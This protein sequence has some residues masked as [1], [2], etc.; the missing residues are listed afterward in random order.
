MVPNGAQWCP[1]PKMA[2]LA[3]RPRISFGDEKRHDLINV[4]NI[5]HLCGKYRN[6]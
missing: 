1:T 4:L 6:I 2:K 5:T 3:A